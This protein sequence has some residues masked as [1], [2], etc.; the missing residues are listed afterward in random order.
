MI[1][2]P[3][4]RACGVALTAHPSLGQV[5]VVTVAG[6]YGPKPLAVSKKVAIARADAAAPMPADFE[7]VLESVPISDIHDQ[8]S[9]G[10]G[11][12]A[13]GYSLLFLPRDA[14]PRCDTTPR[15]YLAA[16]SKKTT[17]RARIC[18]AQVRDA[19]AGG[20]GVELD[21]EP[22]AVKITFERPDG[23]RETLSVDWDATS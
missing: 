14:H 10:H 17:R 9:N 16:V 19:L 18:L 11:R 22:N 20:S 13:R 7:L 8:A 21:Y 12:R 23:T 2:D 4:I 6:G 3:R 1:L 5:T 15:I